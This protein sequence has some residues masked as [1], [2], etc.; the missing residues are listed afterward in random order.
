M[1]WQMRKIILSDTSCLILLHKIQKLDLLEK[2]FGKIIITKEVK[3]EFSDYLPDFFHIQNPKDPNYHKILQTF[4]DKGE[5]SVIALAVE[6]EDCLLIIDDSKGRREAK[7]LGIK[8]TG[9]LGVLLLAKE[10]KLIEELKPLLNQ[11]KS[12]NFRISQSLIYR[13]LAMAGEQ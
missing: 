2:L 3:D 6:N 13:T 1:T 5:A 12:T 4:L 8:I 10:R 11:I 9:T 7:A